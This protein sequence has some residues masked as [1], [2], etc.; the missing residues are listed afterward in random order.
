[1]VQRSIQDYFI[2]L[3]LYIS[4]Q[5]IDT[6]LLCFIKEFI[7]NIEDFIFNFRKDLLQL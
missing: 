1:M 4:E 5:L 3:M 6:E 7:R 2:Y